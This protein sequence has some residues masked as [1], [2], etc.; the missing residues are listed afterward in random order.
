MGGGTTTTTFHRR[1]V[2]KLWNYIKSKA[3][4]VY[5]LISHTHTKS[6]ITDFPTSLPANGGTSTA[7]GRLN[8]VNV[9]IQTGTTKQAKNI[10]E[11]SYDLVDYN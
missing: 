5:A 1:P 7:S 6:Q 2:S 3:D 11:Y 4:S 10:I 8:N 9:A